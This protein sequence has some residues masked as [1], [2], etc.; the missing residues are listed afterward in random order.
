MTSKHGSAWLMLATLAVGTVGVQAQ[1]PI[2]LVSQFGGPNKAV[3]VNGN[4]VY[5]GIGPRLAVL[6]ISDPSSPTL[7]GRSEVFPAVVEDVAVSG[8]YVY[9]AAG[10]GGLLVFDVSSPA[11][12][13]QVSTY[14]MSY[15]AGSLAV[16]G[17]HVFVTDWSTL[18]VIDVSAPASPM[19]VGQFETSGTIQDVAVSGTYAYVTQQYWSGP[20]AHARVRSPTPHNADLRTRLQRGTCDRVLY[21][22]Q[23]RATSAAPTI[24]PDS[25]CRLLRTIAFPDSWG[26][27]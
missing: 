21:V 23:A 7:L 11:S 10:R 8:D 26:G 1:V 13:V 25:Q 6:D 9:V 4:V 14:L 15:G 2:E 5:L 17:H 12:P 22:A 16:V 19:K 24:I 18:Q 27:W 20:I 3:A